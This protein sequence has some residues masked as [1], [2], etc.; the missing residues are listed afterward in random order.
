MDKITNYNLNSFI[1]EKITKRKTSLFSHDISSNYN[2]LDQNIKNKSVLVIGGAGT[3]G[4]E[5]IKQ[6]LIFK[7]RKL[8][9]VDINE[10]GLT[11]LTRELRSNYTQYIP[12]K[13]FSYPMDFSENVFFKMFKKNRTFDIVANF[14]A[15]K[16][17]RS[18]KDIFSVEAMINNNIFK[19]KK[20]LNFLKD[21]KPKHFF[22]V[23]TDKAASPVNLMGAS[24]KIM[25]DLIMS[26]SEIFKVTTARFANVAFSNGSLLAGYINRIQKKQPLSCPND[27]KRFFVSPEESG[28]ICLLSCILGE[29]G[30]IFYP[31]LDKSNLISFRNITEDFAFFI[32]KKIKIFKREYDAKKY[33]QENF[34][35]EELIVYF[36]NSD[37][38]GEKPYEEFFSNDDNIDEKKFRGLGIIHNSLKNSNKKVILFISKIQNSLEKNNVDKNKIVKLFKDYITDFNH[39]EKG[40]NLD[41]KM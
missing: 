39:F 16:H 32:N 23:S 12:E 27:I 40:K 1:K 24:K 3:I 2:L 8:V 26:Y 7:P 5:F 22:C 38:T 6:V 9:V 29:S 31:K 11:E 28:Q 14:A 4:S 36:F 15:H 19:A 30:Q 25:E 18:E 33:S 17:V 20:L 41:Q 37:T 34:S 13:Y 21:N 10:N 35:S